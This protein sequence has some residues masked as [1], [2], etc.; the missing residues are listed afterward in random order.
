MV[1]PMF[2]SLFPTPFGYVNYGES[3]R[4][5]NKK[6]IKD[7][8]KERIMSDG[9]KRTFSKNPCGWQ[10][11]NNMEI[12]YESFIEL[13]KLISNSAREIIHKSGIDPEAYTKFK[14]HGFW[15][16]MIFAP[17]GFSQPHIHGSGETVW[18]GVYYPKGLNEIDN[19]NI[20]TEHEHFMYGTPQVPGSLVLK[21]PSGAHKKIVKVPIKSPNYFI[22][23]FSIIPRE[24][25][26]VLFPAYLEH[27]VT[28]TIDHSN[29]YSISFSIRKTP[30]KI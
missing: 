12:K 11:D 25:L 29:R 15:A 3:N 9:K 5:L 28:P 2:R 7:I 23:N 22:T 19:L 8:D 16:N 21:D 4:E 27:Y 14:I 20:L 6:I 17:G 18:T 26:L 10:S 13:S 1:K 24:S 30:R